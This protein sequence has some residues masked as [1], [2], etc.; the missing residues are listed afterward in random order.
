MKLY[1][2]ASAANPQDIRKRI[3]DILYNYIQ[4]DLWRQDEHEYYKQI[5]KQFTV[6]GRKY[7]VKNDANHRLHILNPEGV[8]LYGYSIPSSLNENTTDNMALAI[9]NDAYG[10]A[11]DLDMKKMNIS[12]R[13]NR[14]YFAGG[15]DY[16]GK[17]IQTLKDWTRNG[18]SGRYA[19]VNMWAD[20]SYSRHEITWFDNE[21]EA[22]SFAKEFIEDMSN[23]EY[24]DTTDY[25]TSVIDSQIGEEIYHEGYKDYANGRGRIKI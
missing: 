5:R 16:A 6:N 23:K 9:L 21:D 12:Y 8:D 13:V 24:K 7:A 3:S 10:D 2:N 1:I 20:Y 17:Y 22:I 4:Y 25:M 19:V 15:V 11:I 18:T 14:Q